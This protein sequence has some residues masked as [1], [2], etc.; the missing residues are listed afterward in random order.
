VFWLFWGQWRHRLCGLTGI[1]YNL[2]IRA[3]DTKVMNKQYMQPFEQAKM[4]DGHVNILGVP[5]F[6]KSKREVLRVLTEALVEK[7]LKLPF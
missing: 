2:G 5:V 4:I 1:D 3:M 7:G 6:G